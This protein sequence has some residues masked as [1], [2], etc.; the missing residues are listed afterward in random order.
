MT[1][2]TPQRRLRI[3]WL[4]HL[5]PYP[6]KGGAI[7]RAYHLL[8]QTARHH[9]VDLFTFNQHRLLANY[10][11]TEEA[12]L[13]AAKEALSPLVGRLHI[14]PIPMSTRRHG[15][16][17]MALR[18]LFSKTPY[19]INWLQS[20][21]AFR[22]LEQWIKDGKYDLVHFDTES[23][24][25]YRSLTSGLPTLMDHHNAEAHMLLRRA[26]QERNLLKK[27]YYWQEGTR[28]ERYERRH[29]Q[30]Y[31]HHIVC[32]EE[33][34]LRLLEIDSEL[35]VTVIPNGIDIASTRPERNASPEP[36]LLFIGGLDWYPNHDAVR[37]MLLEIWPLLKEKK[38]ELSIDIIGK[39][40]PAEL[41][42]YGSQDPSIRF[43][44]FVDD[45][46]PYYRDAAMYLCPIRDGGGTKLKI[47]DALAHRL[48]LVAHSIACEGIEVRSG[49]HLLAASNARDIAKAVCRLLDDPAYAQS[50]GDAGRDLVANK[51][52]FSQIGKELADLY[53]GLVLEEPGLSQLY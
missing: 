9:D 10:Y 8:R 3:L 38:P 40:P 47:L 33:D 37:W 14:E 34:R 35:A 22:R 23:L 6:P 24:A 27:L 13:A 43:H 46:E 18:S 15:Q 50:L 45:I 41:L 4:S 25:P 16:L 32:S 51:Y 49:T 44:G 21:S 28:L 26:S 20:P 1:A 17:R 11:P 39:N 30:R 12:G 36:R 29:L 52:D 53:L 7:M 5:I 19:T 2:D 42:E 48:P 31:N